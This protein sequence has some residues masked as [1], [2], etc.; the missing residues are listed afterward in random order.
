MAATSV[1]K[2]EAAC[3]GCK[4]GIVVVPPVGGPTMCC[5]AEGEIAGEVVRSN[6]EIECECGYG[7]APPEIVGDLNLAEC[8]LIQRREC[9]GPPPTTPG[10]QGGCGSGCRPG[11]GGPPSLHN[12]PDRWKHGDKPVYSR[13][14]LGRAMDQLNEVIG[15]A[16]PRL[17]GADGSP[18]SVDFRTGSLVLQSAPPRTG[19]FDPTPIFT[20]NS[21]GASD[22]G[23][24]YG[25]GA[26]WGMQ[27]SRKVEEP[28]SATARV[29]TGNRWIRSYVAKDINGVYWPASG[30]VNSLKEVS[31]KLVETTPE[32]MAYHYQSTTSS[33][34]LLESIRTPAGDRWT[35]TYDTTHTEC[36]RTITGP[37]GRVTTL[38]YQTVSA[39][40]RT[41]T[42]EDPAGRDTVYA[43]EKNTGDNQ[44]DLVKIT[45]PEMCEAEIGYSDHNLN[46]YTDPELNTTVYQ[47]RENGWLWAIQR[48]DNM[49]TTFQWNDWSETEILE[50]DGGRTTIL[51]DGARRIAEILTPADGG[52]AEYTYEDGFLRSY[53]D[54]RG[55]RT[56]LT[57]EEQSGLRTQRLLSYQLPDGAIHGFAYDSNG[58]LKELTDPLGNVTSLVWDGADRTAVVDATGD[59]YSYTYNARGQVIGETDPLGHR[60]TLVYSDTG[61]DEGQL[62][63][64]ENAL[65]QRTSY[66]YDN[67]LQIKR[68]TNAENESTTFMRDD[69]GRVTQRID[70]RGK[71]TAFTYNNNGQVKQT[72]DPLGN[73]TTNVYDSRGRVE[74]TVD[75][76][77]RRTSFTYDGDGDLKTVTNSAGEI[78][79]FVYD[80]AGRLTARVNPLGHRTTF[81]YDEA[82]NRKWITDALDRITSFTYD[83]LNRMHSS[84]TSLGHRTT[85]AYDLAGNLHS[86][87]NPLGAI[88]TNHYT[89]LNQLEAVED[90]LGHRTSSVYD[91][92]R[93][94]ATENARG[95][96][97]TTVYDDAGRVEAMVNAQNRRVT[98]TYDLAGRLI[99][100]RDPLGF[101]T[102]TVYDDAGNVLQMINPLG[103]ITSYAYDDAGR[104][105]RSTNPLGHIT[106]FNFDDAGQLESTVN[107]LGHIT[108]FLYDD[109]G[110]QEAVQDA[111]NHRTSTAYDGAGRP[112]ATVSALGHRTTIVYDEA[113]QRKALV[114]ARGNRTSF[115]YDD[116]GRVR[117]QLDP[118]GRRTTF[119]YDDAGRMAGRLDARNIITT[120]GYNSAGLLVDQLSSPSGLLYTFTYDENNNR[121]S[122]ADPTGLTTYG[123]DSLD[124]VTQVNNPE[125][126]SVRY[127]HTIRD[128]RR[129]MIE[130]DGSHF[131]YTY[132]AAGRLETLVNPQSELTTFAWDDAGRLIEQRTDDGGLIEYRTYDAADRLTEIDYRKANNDPV[133]GIAY[134]THDNVGNPL[135]Y[136]DGFFSGS[137]KYDEAYQL[138]NEQRLS[139]EPFNVTHSYD[140][141]GNRIEMKS[142][143]G[144]TTFAYDAANQLTSDAEVG[145]LLATYTYDAAGNLLEIAPVGASST[146]FQWD[147]LNRM[148]G[149]YPSPP[150]VTMTYNADGQ[151]VHRLDNS[152][153][154]SFV[155]DG[156]NILMQKE[157]ATKSLY[158]Y[159]PRMYGNLISHVKGAN[160]RFHL[161]DAL[162]STTRLVDSNQAE[163]YSAVY[164]AFGEVHTSSGTNTSPYG[165]VGRVGYRHEP[166][167]G[168][169]YHVRA[170]HYHPGTAR[171]TSQDPL[172]FEGGDAN[173]HRYA[174][175]NPVTFI[176]PSGA[177]LPV[178]VIV[179]G[180]V[181]ARAIWDIAC[182][183]ACY[184]RDTTYNVEGKIGGPH[185]I[186]LDRIQHCFNN[187]CHN[188]CTLFTAP[189]IPAA[190]WA[191]IEF[192]QLFDPTSSSEFRDLVAN[193][194][195]LLHSY[196]VFKSCDCICHDLYP[197]G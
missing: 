159:E 186:H 42:V 157:G 27:F 11:R 80:Q 168:P 127:A 182:S 1:T 188:R 130:P 33:D 173:L 142:G 99:E 59:R 10:G 88:T 81:S 106:S 93:Q 100:R 23:S 65:G 109:A 24:D 8:K 144:Y 197:N 119:S 120:F 177:I 2:D 6:E 13:H 153:S 113:G 29:I 48:A 25:Y 45:T 156:Q 174:L 184:R 137:W 53:T 117:T 3:L 108:S 104:R 147:E 66:V 20:Y 60:F 37:L 129:V 18:A 110:R 73:I 16:T 194:N 96:R 61:P 176:D 98:L 46:N 39:S 86:V 164:K 118:L 36:V 38:T 181:A 125:G 105:T 40:E 151:L 44:Y 145:Q 70:A 178:V 5:K 64:F 193:L 50:P 95:F 192:V 58:R 179:V 143:G 161:F 107:P 32:G 47:Y 89:V 172:G 85:L 163:V 69:M 79:S 132:D 52:Q 78:S 7:L 63:A 124:R 166:S 56:T 131:T 55:N 140:P 67:N 121:V 12:L 94:V 14:G 111:E 68:V 97:T 19:L 75:P 35:L 191:A 43:L 21:R 74:A 162:G 155:W 102:T 114:D 187:C 169:L 57:Y 139:F 171:W 30:V 115:L 185:P 170:R 126:K 195:G 51:Y 149:A 82:G 22:D 141:V 190:I 9:A 62:V 92:G 72:T 71:I 123:Y 54:P 196:N 148:T 83:D 41:I 76:L 154:T 175:S 84:I 146:T 31:G 165:W 136:T 183:Y 90:A 116:D 122:M 101:R 49:D 160:S 28:S 167:L 152:L 150:G 133:W 158:T 77:N 17:P 135:S 134:N 103:H 87:T 138:I 189:Q 4:D 128:E 26:G 15:Q 91:A 112:E 34:G 180:A